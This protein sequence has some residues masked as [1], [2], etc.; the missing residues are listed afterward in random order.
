MISTSRTFVAVCLFVVAGALPARGAPIVYSAASI[1]GVGHLNAFGEVF[2]APVG[3]TVLNEFGFVLQTLATPYDVGAYV[4]KW[5]GTTV[6]G[7]A[8]YSASTTFSGDG[9]LTFSP[10]LTLTGGDTYIAMFSWATGFQEGYGCVNIN[11]D[12]PV[13]PSPLTSPFYSADLTEAGWQTNAWNGPNT[14]RAAFRIQLG[15]TPTDVVSPVP[16]PATL[17]LVALGLGGAIRTRLSRCRR[18]GR[19]AS[20]APGT[21]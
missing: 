2:V 8:L 11:A 18:T 9:L 19:P 10:G 21:A 5:G 1:G 14:V 13:N 12:C 3:N 6:T 15:A 16:E 7:A 17:S 4:Y 20:S